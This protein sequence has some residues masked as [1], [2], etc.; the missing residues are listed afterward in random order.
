MRIDWDE[1]RCASLGMCEGV[2]PEVFEV[3]ED[4]ELA[5]L[6]EEP[7]EGSRARDEKGGADMIKRFL[8][9]EVLIAVQGLLPIAEELGLTPAQ[10]AVAW[11]LS[12]DNVAGAIIGASRPEQVTE[13]VKASGVRLEA[14]VMTR[15]DEVLGDL[16]ETDPTKTQSP[17]HRLA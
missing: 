4:G 16:P 8:N 14:D 6:V 1:H 3:G 10:L 15:I 9:D 5:V 13:N 7:P 2:A 11:V 17:A 12:N